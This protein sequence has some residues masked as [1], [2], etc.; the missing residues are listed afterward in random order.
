MNDSCFVSVLLGNH[1]K[2]SLCCTVNCV[3]RQSSLRSLKHKKEW[4]RDSEKCFLVINWTCDETLTI[5]PF[6]PS[7]IIF[8][9][10]ICVTLITCFTLALNKLKQ[11]KWRKVYLHILFV[12]YRSI[13]SG[14]TSKKGLQMAK[15]ALLT[16][17]SITGRFSK[18]TLVAFQSVRSKAIVW[19]LGHSSYKIIV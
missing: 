13:S 11:V 9:V 19:I 1:V 17:P 16:R 8:P 4:K 6:L 15:A 18:A 7:E 5:D 10:T 2:S 12:I 14:G 3:V